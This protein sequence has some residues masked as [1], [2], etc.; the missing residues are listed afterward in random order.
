MIGIVDARRS[1]DHVALVSVFYAS[2]SGYLPEPVLRNIHAHE[3]FVISDTCSYS[4]IVNNW[5]NRNYNSH[6]YHPQNYY[7]SNCKRKHI[8]QISKSRI[9]TPSLEEAA[10]QFFDRLCSR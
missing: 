8:Q 10:K 3:L 6:T 7:N 9:K 1:R 2:N 4:S 5:R